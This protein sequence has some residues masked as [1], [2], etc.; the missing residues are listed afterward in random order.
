MRDFSALPADTFTHCS[1]AGSSTRNMDINNDRHQGV[2]ERSLLAENE[3]Y[4]GSGGV[5][6]NNRRTGFKPAFRNT[7]TGRTE[8]S[9]FADGRVAPMHIIEGL[10]KEWA[11][12]VDV[13]G[14]PLELKP[15]IVVGFVKDDRFYTRREVASC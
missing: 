3:T 7:E 14:F 9:R 10:P 1:S 8:L 15:E 5:S 12:V 6:K 4:A 11:A 13:K 2:T